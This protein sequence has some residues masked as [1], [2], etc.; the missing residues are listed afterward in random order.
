MASKNSKVNDPE[1]KRGPGRPPAMPGEKMTNHMVR[2][3][4]DVPDLI[5]ELAEARGV[6]RGA[7]VT[8]L[9]RQAA[10][11]RARDQARKAAKASN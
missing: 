6:S 9:I 3:A 5:G 8:T 7:L 1:V 4:E 2:V 11:R 10:Q